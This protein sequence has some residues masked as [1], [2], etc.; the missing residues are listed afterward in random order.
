[1]YSTVQI[2]FAMFS[3]L[4]RYLQHSHAN[5]FDDYA[6]IDTLFQLFEEFLTAQTRY[7]RSHDYTD[8]TMARR[9]FK[10]QSEKS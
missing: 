7:P 9:A 5:E 10:K 2:N 8:M 6:D 3:I 1:M 4:C